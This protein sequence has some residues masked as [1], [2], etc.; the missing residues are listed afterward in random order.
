MN[1]YNSRG[2]ESI[3]L[4]RMTKNQL[5]MEMADLNDSK[6]PSEVINVTREELVALYEKHSG[7]RLGILDYIEILDFRGLHKAFAPAR[8]EFRQLADWYRKHLPEM[9]REGYL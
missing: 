1:H 9:I 5:M 8:N 3:T 6:L 4:G 7:R 2:L